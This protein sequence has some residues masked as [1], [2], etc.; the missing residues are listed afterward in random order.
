M[1]IYIIVHNQR[2]VIRLD[3]I[4]VIL[5]GNQVDPVVE[6]PSAVRNVGPIIPGFFQVLKFVG[7]CVARRVEES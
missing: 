6:I 2:Q 4:I 3:E 5:V 1:V 7:S